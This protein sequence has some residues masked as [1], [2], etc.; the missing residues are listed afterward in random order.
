MEKH[1]SYSDERLLLAMEKAALDPEVFTHEAHLRWGWLLMRK[2]GV[3][4]AVRI[5]CKHLKDYTIQLGAAD[6]Y[7]ETVTVAAVRAINHFQMRC[8]AE[9]FQEFL[10]QSP[11]LKHSFKELLGSHYSEDIF[12]SEDARINYLEPDLHPFD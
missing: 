1:N 12:K 10:E 9:S 4:A 7:N 5:A 2:N 8:R 6:K 11:G 3:E